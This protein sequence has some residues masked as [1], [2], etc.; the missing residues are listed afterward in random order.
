MLKH[1]YSSVRCVALSCFSEER[2][3]ADVRAAWDRALLGKVAPGCLTAMPSAGHQE[4]AK[5][6]ASKRADKMRAKEKEEPSCDSPGM[7]AAGVGMATHNGI[8]AASA[9]FAS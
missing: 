6:D 1:A 8:Y 3:L 5:R 7:R 9:L 4:H 2:F